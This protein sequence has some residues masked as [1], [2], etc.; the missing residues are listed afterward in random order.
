MVIYMSLLHSAF[1]AINLYQKL[2]WLSV[3][4]ADIP[5]TNSE[6]ISKRRKK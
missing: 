6:N 3:N 4:V 2:L 1:C 5:E